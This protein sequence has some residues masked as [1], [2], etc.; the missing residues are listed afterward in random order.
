MRIDP[1][2]PAG[3][4]PAPTVA[5]PEGS[6]LPGGPQRTGPRPG[7]TGPDDAG[8]RP[9]GNDA[10]DGRPGRSEGGTTVSEEAVA[11]IVGTAAR[12][13]PGVHDLGGGPGPEQGV[14]VEV[15][16]RQAAADLDLVIEYGAS[17]P[18]LATAVRARVVSAVEDMTG[19]EVVEV[20]LRVT[21]VHLPQD[22]VPEGKG[23]R[24]L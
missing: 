6:P 14:Q 2:D 13:V 4:G 16:R 15:G 24:V 5:R 18:E 8:S 23:R 19:L 22:D 3:H 1:T 11:K 12:E 21:D 7:G 9:N 20:N 17:V 10:D